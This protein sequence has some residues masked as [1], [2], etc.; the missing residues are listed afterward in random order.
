VAKQARKFDSL[1]HA[2][3][4]GSAADVR[5]FLAAGADPNENEE[6]GDVTPLMC[7]AA[8]G[9]LEIVRVLVEAGA[10]V[11]ALAEDLSGDLDEFTFLDEAY[12]EGEL[13]GMTALLYATLYGHAG[14]RKYLAPLTSAELRSQARAV[15]RRAQRQ[16]ED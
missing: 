3:A 16:A 10:D 2:V 14:V 9:D 7:A 5:R 8:R 13:H 6:A 1:Y 11:N 15:E 4:D 12:Q